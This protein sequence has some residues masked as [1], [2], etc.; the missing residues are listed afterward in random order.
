MSALKKKIGAGEFVITAE[1][2]PPL[3]AAPDKLLA[4]AATLVNDVSDVVALNTLLLTPTALHAMQWHDPTPRSD[5]FAVAP[6][7]ASFQ[8]RL[9]AE[10]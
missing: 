4:E 6:K 7:A 1:I 8:M 10:R 2:V 9:R 5:G 3:S